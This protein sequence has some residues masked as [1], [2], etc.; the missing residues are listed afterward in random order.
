MNNMKKN[1]HVTRVEWIDEDKRARF[2]CCCGETRDYCVGG[3][4]VAGRI[5]TRG[6]ALAFARA[7]AAYHVWSL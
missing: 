5:D 2:T 6:A 4:Y 1:Q 3:T 7:A